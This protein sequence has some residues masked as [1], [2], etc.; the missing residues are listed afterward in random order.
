MNTLP[1]TTYTSNEVLSKDSLEALENLGMVL[2]PIYLRMKKEGYG[3]VN[4]KVVK[5]NEYE[6]E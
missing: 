6:N 4:G 3:I 5:L 1:K 2:K